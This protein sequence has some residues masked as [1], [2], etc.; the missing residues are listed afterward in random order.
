ME[1]Q[2]SREPPQGR[3][4]GSSGINLGHGRLPD[5][6]NTQ[7]GS[8]EV[9]MEP[10]RIAEPPQ[11]VRRPSSAELRAAARL[12]AHQLRY[13][14]QP[15]VRDTTWVVPVP[16]R[17]DALLDVY[18]RVRDNLVDV[19]PESA[20]DYNAASHLA[21]LI[22]AYSLASIKFDRPATVAR[23]TLMSLEA[24]THRFE[25][26]TRLMLARWFAV[27][28]SELGQRAWDSARLTIYGDSRIAGLKVM[29]K[30]AKLWDVNGDGQWRIVLKELV[31]F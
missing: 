7:A 13:T 17:R 15:E 5:T 18:R 26:E 20:A 3:G 12:H 23:I 27:R 10:R 28:P 1:P 25:P 6:A 24:F 9:R 22:E 8:E 19:P 29:S 4:E 21:V 11:A 2:S 16:R 30:S 14:G 31:E